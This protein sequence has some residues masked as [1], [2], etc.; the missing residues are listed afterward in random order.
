VRE[1]DLPPRPLGQAVPRS[2][3]RLTWTDAAGSHTIELS[4]ERTAGSAP[5][6]DIVIADR[7]VSRLH[8]AL[9]PREDGLWL[10]DLA[11]RN[12][13]F[14][15]GLRVSEARVP[16]AANVRVGATEISVA[17]GPPRLP[18]R[19]SEE[20]SFGSL[21]GGSAVMRELF[22]AAADFAPTDASILILGEEGTGVGALARAIHDHSARA[23]TPF[24]VVECAALP[25]PLAAA[26]ILEKALRD[27]EGGTLVLD[28]PQALS[29]AVQR[30]LVPPIDAKA[31]R[32]IA[33]SSRDLRPLVN[34]GAFRE[35]LYF[36]LAG[37]T[38]RMPSL[39]E[40]I[41]DLP[42][43]LRRFLGP[44]H[45]EL[46]TDALLEDLARLPWTGNVREL[47]MYADRLRES[48]GQMILVPEPPDPESEAEP[49]FDAVEMST[50][51]GPALDPNA[52]D[53]P[54]SSFAGLDPWFGTGF[55]E[56]REKWIEL[57]ER[58]YLRRLMVRTNRSSSAAS[59][60]AG[61]ER[62]YLYRLLKKHGV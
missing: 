36:R 38:L 27:A 59:R 24:V 26:E 56:F 60:E 17:Y 12:G 14:I 9:T 35:A 46:A 16:G 1:S 51:E 57:G 22:A 42:L 31:F 11:S 45:E 33:T 61:L 43:L 50:M 21:E 23:N 19:L 58:E 5:G 4:T 10:K 2:R 37:A 29:L 54:P 52:L 49:S 48:G 3:P 34:Q 30:E 32:A 13:T 53:I 62:T 28:E 15:G 18:E 25:D 41:S 40:R 39:R 47:R 20:E 8:V 6:C 7:A 55:K 44:E